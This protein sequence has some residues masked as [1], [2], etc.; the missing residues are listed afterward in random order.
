MYRL[1]AMLYFIISP[2]LAGTGIIA[3]LVAGQD[4]VGAIVGVAAL[5]ALLALPVSYV[6]ATKLVSV[7]IAK[8]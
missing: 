6:I 1:A 5:G 7:S 4:T 2:S 3:V 8:R